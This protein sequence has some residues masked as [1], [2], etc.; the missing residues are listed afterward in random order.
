MLQ[1]APDDLRHL[2]LDVMQACVHKKAL[3]GYTTKGLSKTVDWITSP[4]TKFPTTRN[5]PPRITFFTA[6]VWY[7]GTEAWRKDYD[8]GVHDYWTTLA[9]SDE[10]GKA[11][12]AAHP[13]SIVREELD[14]RSAYIK[15]AAEAQGKG[16][17]LKRVWWTGT[18][19]RSFLCPFKQKFLEGFEEWR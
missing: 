14:R 8:P 18:Y 9:I 3:G 5:L 7:A 19:F 12:E 1:I 4:G 6:M 13:H 17:D 10:L 2:A 11:I 15:A 16:R